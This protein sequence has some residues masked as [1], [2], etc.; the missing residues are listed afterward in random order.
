MCVCVFNVVYVYVFGY[1]NLLFIDEY[2]Q[3]KHVMM[4]HKIVSEEN[5]GWTV[6]IKRSLM[7]L[8]RLDHKRVMK[9]QKISLRHCIRQCLRLFDTYIDS[10]SARLCVNISYSLRAQIETCVTSMTDHTN[11]ARRG[12]VGG[13]RASET[14]EQQMQNL[15]KL[16][17]L[18]DAV[19]GQL[20]ELMSSDSFYRFCKTPEFKHYQKH[21]RS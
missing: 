9:A 18:F 2:M 15:L 7:Q 1:R 5:I 3:L 11:G 12:F 8:R 21:L 14:K 10:V 20:Y 13:A 16:V 6:D 17:E 4:H 19:S